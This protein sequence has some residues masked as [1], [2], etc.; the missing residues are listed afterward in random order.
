MKVFEM[1]FTKM[2]NHFY[3][4]QWSFEYLFANIQHSTGVHLHNLCHHLFQPDLLIPER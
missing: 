4:F 1:F 2:V 3:F